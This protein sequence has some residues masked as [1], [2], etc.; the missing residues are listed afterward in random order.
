MIK[1]LKKGFTLVELIV[2][3]AI[4][5]ILSTVAIIGFTRV[6][7]KANVSND[8]QLVRN[9][10]ER[11]QL[12][13]AENGYKKPTTA[14]EAFVLTEDF[15]FIIEKLT[16][17]SSGN[18]IVWDMTTNRF[19]LI[20][21]TDVEKVIYSDPQVT[22]STNPVDL[23]KVY[24][25]V[26]KLADQKYSIY[27]AGTNLA[28]IVDAKVGLDVGEN[29][30]IT[31]INYT[32]TSGPNGPTKQDVVIRTN[33]FD[34]VVT[35]TAFES[36]TFGSNDYKCDSIRHF[37]DAKEVNIIKAGQASY[38]EFG[39]VGFTQVASG[40]FVA[41]AGSKTNTVVAT[42]E[43]AVIVINGGEIEHKYATDASFGGSNS[44]GNVELD[45]IAPTD[46]EQ[47]K[48]EAIAAITP[49][50]N[51]EIVA[52]TIKIVEDNENG[53]KLVLDEESVKN[54]EWARY[55]IKLNVPFRFYEYTT[56]DKSGDSNYEYRKLDGSKVYLLKSSESEEYNLEFV[57]SINKG[58]NIN[59]VPYYYMAGFLFGHEYVLDNSTDY[60]IKTNNGSISVKN[61]RYGF[62]EEEIEGS[63]YSDPSMIYISSKDLVNAFYDDSDASRLYCLIMNETDVSTYSISVYD[64]NNNLLGSTEY[65]PFFV[66]VDEALEQYLEEYQSWIASKNKEDT[67]ASV[68]E[69]LE[70][71]NF[72]YNGFTVKKIREGTTSDG[73]GD[74]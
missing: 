52:P 66:G 5:A 74:T 73:V 62:S 65:K 8:T 6:V 59:F 46:V 29:L 61:V 50:P 58:S 27:L 37:G 7:D 21:A 22:L 33:S 23:W 51:A 68:N 42:S 14:H 10:N 9:L 43:Y 41:E 1:K 54:V 60:N 39:N 32:N 48:Q 55:E 11:M 19:A 72:E 40:K 28:G 38:H 15:G 3:I 47:K 70:A 56:V 25:K 67:R 20:D 2:V 63:F 26:P 24:K 12:Y 13:E 36:G 44:K 17:T 69:F 34:T 45:V 16:P 53:Y 4:I 49:D 64:S 31:E 71:H 57:Y 35:V 18:D 30:G